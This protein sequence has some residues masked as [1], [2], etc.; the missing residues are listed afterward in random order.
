ME[1]TVEVATVDHLS[2]AEQVCTM[3]E[4]AAKARGTGI[5][6]R[7][8]AYI[9]QKIEQGKAIIALEGKNL[10]GFCYIETW[11]HDRYVANSGLI[12]N[13]TYR[14]SGLAKRIKRRAFELSR[15]KY[16]QAKI[17]GITTSLAVMKIN[18]DLGYKP[19]TFSELTD[20][21]SFWKGCSSCPNYDVLTRTERK[22][23][24]CTGMLYEPE[25]P[26]K[27]TP[28]AKDNR[29]KNFKDFLQM[30]KTR[31]LYKQFVHKYFKK[32]EV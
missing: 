25:A 7:E 8:P 26:A 11:G 1:F 14:K 23:C 9:R 3:I 16:P 10:A 20:D 22:I 24:L 17:F 28:T 12:V 18:S 31:A 27:K 4:D 29:W 19:V 13:S 6:K 15:E 5:A 21:E 2:Y 32:Q 30:R